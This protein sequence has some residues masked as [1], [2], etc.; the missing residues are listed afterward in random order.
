VEFVSVCLYVRTYMHLLVCAFVFL[1]AISK[2]DASRI[3][4]L[5]MDMVHYESWKS[6]YFA[7]KRSK[8]RGTKSLC[9]FYTILT[10]AAGITLHHICAADAADRW[11]FLVW[12]F[13]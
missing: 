7:V 4:K 5:D 2:T 12:S 8:L 11:F 10:F 6:I 3:T 9:W 1:H 13:L